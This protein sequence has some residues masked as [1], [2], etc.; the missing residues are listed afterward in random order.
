MNRRT[1][2]RW[3]AGC[4]AVGPSGVWSQASAPRETVP[5][6]YPEL[7]EPF[8]SVFAQILAGL[9]ER[10][11]GRVERHPVPPQVDPAPL[12]AELGKRKPRV[13]VAL[14]RAALK[15][16]L[17]L[18]CDVVGSGII[19]PAEGDSRT[20]A[21]LSLAP[22]PQLLFQRLK[23]LAPGVRRVTVVFSN[24]S[25]G[26]LMPLAKDA[27][28]ATG[29]ELRT[30][31]AEDLKT[32]L[33]HYQDFFAQASAPDALW[34]PQDPGTVDEAAVL[35]LVIQES[36]NRNVPV[37]SSNL[38]HVRRGALFSLYPN[39]PEL[40]RTLGTTTLAVLARTGPTKGPQALRDV[41]AALNTRTASHL[42]V[43]LSP[44]VQRTYDLLLPER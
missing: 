41:H 16:A 17:T 35:P 34:L 26:W 43:D 40:G 9:D 7:G 42:G 33:R 20:A 24:R 13:V 37:F 10:L 30:L 38:A 6:L 29:L 22:D 36:W 12:A 2:C 8:R 19:S 23:L 27:A 1:W 44:Q 4:W 11:A 28:R 32:A 15:T 21:L 3:V 5:V 18:D 39:N 25:S 14:G 31:E